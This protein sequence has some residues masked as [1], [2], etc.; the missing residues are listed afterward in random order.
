M[1][2]DKSDKKKLINYFLLLPKYDNIQQNHESL[3]KYYTITQIVWNGFCRTGRSQN[4]KNSSWRAW[5]ETQEF[6][7][8]RKT[9]EGV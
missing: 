1:S 6:H 4:E 9:E 8:S 7:D 5:E 3:D 2:T